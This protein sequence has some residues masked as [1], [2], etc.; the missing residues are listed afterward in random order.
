[1]RN[2]WETAIFGDEANELL[3]PSEDALGKRDDDASDA[4][5]VTL[6]KAE[7]DRLRGIGP[8]APLAKRA[9]TKDAPMELFVRLSKIDEAQRLVYGI[10]TSETP[11]RDGEILDYQGSKPF[12]EE[13][14]NSVRRDS[15][16]QSVGNLR[17]MHGA[18]AAGKLSQIVFNDAAKQIEVCAKVVDDACWKKVL[19]RVYSG[20][21]IGGKYVSTKKDGNLTRFVASPS[22]IS[23]VDRPS[24]PTATFSLVKVDGS[25]EICKFEDKR[26]PMDSTVLKKF[27]E[28]Q[29]EHHEVMK[30]AHRAA[31]AAAGEGTSLEVF[32][33]AAMEQHAS[34][35]AACADCADDCAKSE[36]ANLAKVADSVALA[37]NEDQIRAV[38]LKMFG[39]TLMPTNV[40]AVTP[41]A[42]AGQ[43][44]TTPAAAAVV[45]KIPLEFR[46]LVSV[47]DGQDAPGVV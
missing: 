40:S 24:C 38:F 35:S 42:R 41:I 3:T 11:D 18:V 39:N 6:E 14:S 19:E 20:F 15:G 47:E 34:R 43:P 12:F 30:K 37:V 7:L 13:W 8:A 25:V 2:Y 45:E 28:G 31:L 27:F 44:P 36:K 4:F 46:K 21:S 1:M 17:E 9:L 32:H 23:L 22:E 29:A 33:K 26:E 10:A 16:G 5:S